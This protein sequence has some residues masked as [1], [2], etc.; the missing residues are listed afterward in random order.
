MPPDS[1]KSCVLA[2]IYLSGF[3]GKS[4]VKEIEHQHCDMVCT[5]PVVLLVEV[6]D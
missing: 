1:T 3:S 4:Y 6:F 2:F 5:S